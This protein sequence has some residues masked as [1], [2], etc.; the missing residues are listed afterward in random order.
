MTAGPAKTC[1]PI[2][3]CCPAGAREA[4]GISSE[5]AG[6][7]DL[8]ADGA[9][10][11]L[12]AVAYMLIEPEQPE[13]PADPLAVGLLP[14]IPSMRMPPMPQQRL[15]RDPSRRCHDHG[16]RPGAGRR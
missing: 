7:Y 3:G 4:D 6:M 5:T 8:Y 9:Q 14:T 11:F 10:M 12:N 15:R 2:A 16:R 13:E 1:W